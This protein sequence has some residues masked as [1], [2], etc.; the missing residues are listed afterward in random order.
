MTARRR[1][2]VVAAVICCPP[3]FAAGVAIA[4]TCPPDIQRWLFPTLLLGFVLGL[5]T[6]RHEDRPLDSSEVRQPVVRR[7]ATRR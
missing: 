4:A 7:S 2:F 5:L 6:G 3:G 1:F